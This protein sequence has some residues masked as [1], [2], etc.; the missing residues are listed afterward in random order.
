MV[1][2]KHLSNFWKSLEMPLINYEINLILT[3]SGN[4]AMFSNGF[5]NQGATFSIA[6]T[7]FYVPV[8]TLSNAKLLKQLKSGFQKTINFNKF[9]SKPESLREDARL[10]HLVEPSFQG[11]NRRFVFIF[12]Y[13]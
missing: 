2:L 5:A 9:T 3:W 12:I 13:I 10:N 4:C 8:V 7:K 6:E 1:P 11:I